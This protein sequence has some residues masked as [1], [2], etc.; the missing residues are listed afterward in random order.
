MRLLTDL[1]KGSWARAS[2]IARNL[3]TDLSFGG[4]YGL[5]SQAK[6]HNASR[7]SKGIGPTDYAVLSEIFD[8][9]IRDNDTIVDVGCGRGRVIRWLISQGVKQQIFGVEL[10]ED[11][12]AFANR[13]LSRY[14]NVTIIQG[15]VLDNIPDSASLFYLANSFDKGV[16]D[17]FRTKLEER[18]SPEENTVILYSNCVH[19]S[20]FQNSPRWHTEILTLHNSIPTLPNQMAVI[21]AR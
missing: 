10:D 20:V 19:V 18:K 15:D 11:A 17:A 3:L 13:K 2:K 8:G 1:N 12:F 7:G 9:R 6:S 14:P 16:T 4:L 21:S 5:G